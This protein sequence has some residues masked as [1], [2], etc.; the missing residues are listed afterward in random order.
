MMQT[1]VIVIVMRADSCYM[2]SDVFIPF[3]SMRIIDKS[4]Q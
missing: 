2:N 3:E 1:A 4:G